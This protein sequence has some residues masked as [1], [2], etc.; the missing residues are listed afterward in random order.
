MRIPSRATWLHLAF[1]TV[2]MASEGAAETADT[3]FYFEWSEFRAGCVI[4]EESSSVVSSIVA[5]SNYVSSATSS[6]M[7][8]WTNT[9]SFLFQNA[10]LVDSTLGNKTVARGYLSDNNGQRAEDVLGPQFPGR[11]SSTVSSRIL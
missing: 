11:F 3:D 10:I 8:F 2:A 4:Q 7:F 1:L 6:M 5:Y 9:S